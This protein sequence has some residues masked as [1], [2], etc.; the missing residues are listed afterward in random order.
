[1]VSPS[2]W[3]I[4]WMGGISPESAH[5]TFIQKNC[6]KKARGNV[7]FWLLHEKQSNLYVCVCFFVG[8]S[9]FCLS[10]SPVC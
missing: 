9:V 3:S 6:K 2:G 8:F 7:F 5:A 1:M 10:A 4:Q